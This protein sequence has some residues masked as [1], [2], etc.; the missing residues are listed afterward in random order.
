MEYLT[1]R[2]IQIVAGLFVL[3]TLLLLIQIDSLVLQCTEAFF[4]HYGAFVCCILV[5]LELLAGYAL[6]KSLF[7]RPSR[8]ILKLDATEE[9]RQAFR[10][11]MRSRLRSNPHLKGLGLKPDDPEFTTKAMAHLDELAEQEI[12]SHGKKVF[13]GTAL[14]QN[15]KLDALIMFLALSRMVYRVSKIYNQKPSP[16]ELWSVLSTV[17][18]STFVAFSIE[19]LDIPQTITDTM[20]E[21]VPAVA[22]AMAA[23]SVPFMG[24]ALHVFTA[25]LIDGAANCLLAVRAGVITR[26]AYNYALKGGLEN[27]R[28][29]CVR[30]TG[31]IML[32]ISKESLSQVVKALTGEIQ[33]LSVRSSQKMLTKAGKAVSDLGKSC[34]AKVKESAD[35]VCET[36]QSVANATVKTLNTG[37]L[38]VASCA[39]SGAD[40]CAINVVNL[41]K[42]S[43]YVMQNSINLTLNT[44]RTRAEYVAKATLNAS[45]K[46][47]DCAGGVA[48]LAK[49]SAE[50]VGNSLDTTLNVVINSAES[51]GSQACETMSDCAE[52]VVSLAKNSALKVEESTQAVLSGVKKMGQSAKETLSQVGENVR[53]LISFKRSNS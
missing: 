49:S 47:G 51:L 37:A 45:H 5:G 35:L 3:L 41:A 32:D 44:V 30:E 25:S 38:K 24:S 12:R 42:D 13:L 40:N 36:S 43:S 14:S 50:K 10:K 31:A 19:A 16:D 2:V 23:S 11:E 28:R 34:G 27:L 15:G 33:D 8:L 20:N 46:V 52:G 48:T 29:S 21:L 53:N 26:R 9:E 22:P 4:P 17:S 39:K 6:Y 1:K 18:S 7:G